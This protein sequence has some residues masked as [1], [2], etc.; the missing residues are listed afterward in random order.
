MDPVRKQMVDLIV[1]VWDMLDN[2]GK[3]SQDFVNKTKDMLDSEFF[4]M[5]RLIVSPETK[6]HLYLEL[7]AF[8]NEP[9]FEQ[10]EEAADFLGV[11]LFDY[12]A[13]PHLSGDSEEPY[14]TVHPVFT[15]YA[16]IRRVQQI[17]NKKNK[18]PTSVD[19]R[20]P[21]TGQ[22]TGHSKAARL[23][24]VE[25][26]ALIAHGSYNILNEFFTLRSGDPVAREG[27]A[28]EIATKGS[29]S[30]EELDLDRRNRV[31]LN[32]AN[33]VLLGAGIETNLIT[34]GG[35]LKRTLE[36]QYKDPR[37]LKRKE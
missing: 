28:H 20:N 12:V 16:N 32:T 25:V 19:E 14:Y 8:E 34:E 33:V 21:R 24:D 6:N 1:T 36:K 4:E 11:K 27:A 5:M 30:L 18:I 31:A 35:V 9:L 13:F 2:T 29:C 22:V 17:V 3:C 15:G 26:V 37:G 10:I 23:S 7:E